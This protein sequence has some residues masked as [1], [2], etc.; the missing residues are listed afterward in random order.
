MQFWSIVQGVASYS[1]TE[2]LLLVSFGL[3]TLKN[4]NVYV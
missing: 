4:S 2:K 3:V 1:D